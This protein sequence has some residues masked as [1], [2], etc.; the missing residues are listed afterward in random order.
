MVLSF[1]LS[2][3]VIATEGGSCLPFNFGFAKSIDP[4]VGSDS[5]PI[6]L[7]GDSSSSE[8]IDPCPEEELEDPKCPNNNFEEIEEREALDSTL[9]CEV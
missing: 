8:L 9:E 4:R 7:V 5:N 2:F 6:G 3:K 1:P